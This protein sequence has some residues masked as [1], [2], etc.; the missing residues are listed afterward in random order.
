VKVLGYPSTWP[1]QCFL[2]NGCGAKV[3]AHTNGDGDFVLFDELGPS[4]PV[5]DCYT[6]RVQTFAKAETFR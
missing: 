1:T 4:W 2:A 5:H 6:N 3:F